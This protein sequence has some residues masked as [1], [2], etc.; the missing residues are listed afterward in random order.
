MREGSLLQGGYRLLKQIDKS[1]NSIVYLAVDERSNK[2]LAIKEIKR[3]YLADKDPITWQ[4]FTENIRMLINF[5][6]R[7]LPIFYEI[8][9]DIGSVFIV[10]EYIEGVKLSTY[11]QETKALSVDNAVAYTKQLCS[12]LSYLHNQEKPYFCENLIPENILVKLDGTLVL[13]GFGSLYSWNND[14]QN[15]VIRSGIRGYISPERLSKSLDVKIDATSDIYSLGTIMYYMLTGKNPSEPPYILKPIRQIDP[16]LPIRLEQIVTKATAKLQQDRYQRADIMLEAFDKDSDEPV[17]D[18]KDKKNNV[19]PV[20][21]GGIAGIIIA[22]L[23]IILFNFAFKKPSKETRAQVETSS[24]EETT[25]AET[26]DIE[27]EYNAKFEEL[28]TKVNLQTFDEINNEITDEFIA[29]IDIDPKRDEAAGLYYDYLKVLNMEGIDISSKCNELYD[30]IKNNESYSDISPQT[31]YWL[32]L[33]YSMTGDNEKQSDCFEILN[34]KYKDKIPSAE[35]FSE[36]AKLGIR[37]EGLDTHMANLANIKVAVDNAKNTNEKVY[38]EFAYIKLFTNF[39]SS[40][41]RELL[42]ANWERLEEYTKDVLY[43][44]DNNPNEI[45]NAKILKDN[46][47]DV[48][49]RLAINVVDNEIYNVY[50][51][52]SDEGIATF[53]YNAESGNMYLEL[54]WTRDLVHWSMQL[55]ADDSYL[56]MY[57]KLIEKYPN[58]VE[59]YFWYMNSV[60]LDKVYNGDKK[61]KIKEIYDKMMSIENIEGNKI[62][63]KQKEAIEG[64]LNKEEG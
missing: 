45:Y 32:G 55:N 18:T 31:L 57:D 30:R 11:L 17:N 12:L 25:V 16:S 52:G 13:L 58:Y 28:K 44:V 63:Q 24:V 35:Y 2:Q 3:E 39:R 8:V 46:T 50:T 41:T 37:N 49:A 36:Y 7:N 19:K 54:R 14:Y 26:K 43:N 20:V 38:Y 22:S 61:A 10:M 42:S 64:I 34:E 53:K 51:G 23:I 60:S 5:K 9:E 40:Y 47:M 27:S 33:L 29:L 62:Y 56:S 59:G 1:S 15:H 4:F 21:I 6:H 48:K